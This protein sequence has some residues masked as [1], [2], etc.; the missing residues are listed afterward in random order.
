MSG[1]HAAEARHDG[2]GE[3]TPLF[4]QIVGRHGWPFADESEP[5]ADV[6]EVDGQRQVAVSA[7]AATPAEPVRQ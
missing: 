4:D 2:A 1:D 7:A 5:D 6:G 3:S